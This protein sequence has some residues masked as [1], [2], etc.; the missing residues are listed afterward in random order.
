[1]V[2][3]LFRD[4]E[5]FAFA[6]RSELPGG[7][8]LLPEF[9][10]HRLAPDAYRRPRLFPTFA[11]RVPSRSRADLRELALTWGVDDVSDPFE[12]LA[13]SGG[14]QATDRIELA[15]YRP[16]DDELERPLEMRVAGATYYPCPEELQAG[17]PLELRRQPDNEHDPLAT[18]VLFKGDVRVGYV[19]RQYVRLV[20]RLLDAGVMLHA[21][22][23][24]RLVLPSDT[25]W[26]I[27]VSRAD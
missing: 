7:F 11:Q 8:A 17:D 13:K 21:E 5:G 6:Y 26:V 9:P 24:R 16:D 20:A 1:M 25:R 14:T 22:A 4:I 3:D 18:L 12:V 2:G 23:L 15:E 27:R 10:V 19:P